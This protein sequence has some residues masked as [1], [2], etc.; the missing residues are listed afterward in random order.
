MKRI[1]TEPIRIQ[2]KDGRVFGY[3]LLDGKIKINSGSFFRNVE[4]NSLRQNI[5][6]QR[7]FL[8]NNGYVKNDQLVKDYIFDNPSLAISSLMGHMDTGNQAFV[9]IDNIEIG[10]YLELDDI[11]A[12]EQMPKDYLLTEEHKDEEASASKKRER[13]DSDDEYGVVSTSDVDVN[14]VVMPDYSPE[15]KPETVTNKR[16]AI[17][18]SETRA[19]NSLILAEFKCDLDNSH[20]SF[21]AKNGKPY[22]EAHHLIPL[23]AQ[24]EFEYSLDVEANIVCLC[25]NCHRLLHYGVNVQNQ[26]E[27]LYTK[28]KQLL[29]RSKILIDFEDLL[30]LYE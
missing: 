30:R 29:E 15:Q 16:S 28:R 14:I 10:S 23:S 18:R 1:L 27:E 6:D 17:K 11:S 7:A 5:R 2:S 24:D 9:T 21:K 13:I 20:V 8:L 3:Y 12:F 25:P 22:M 4:V 19:K 26:L